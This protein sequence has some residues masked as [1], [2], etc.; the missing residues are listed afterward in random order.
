VLILS[1]DIFNACS[2][3]VIAV[4]LTSRTAKGW[5]STNAGTHQPQLAKANLGKNRSDQNALS[6]AA[7]KAHW[8]GI[9]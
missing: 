6:E 5:L 7:G 2:G 9:V 8:Q 3:T 4:A 1:Q